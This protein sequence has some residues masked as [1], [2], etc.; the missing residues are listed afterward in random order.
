MR[1]EDGQPSLRQV[2]AAMIT[3]MDDGIG[4][5]LAALEQSGIADD[6]LVWFLSDNG[7]TGADSEDNLPWRGNKHDLFE[8]GIRVPACVRWPR[9][10]P[11][12]IEV[13]APTAVQ[14]V[15]PT[16]MSIAGVS[17]HQGL[18]LDGVDLLDV[19]RGE[20][21]EVRREFYFYFGQDG[22]EREKL[23][24]VRLP[25]KL[26]ILGPSL[27]RSPLED[28]HQRLLFDLLADPRESNDLSADHAALVEELTRELIEFRRLQPEPSIAPYE[29]G[30]QGFEAPPAWR[31]ESLR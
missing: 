29:H 7:G 19:L 1:D 31:V 24:V 6:T 12:G 18:P 27:A 25:W 28:R 22:E 11:S 8:G 5:I 9:G 14:D 21:R 30:R 20:R 23:A 10:L 4:R 17:D 16:L 3:C 13:D 2:R 15:L 26:V